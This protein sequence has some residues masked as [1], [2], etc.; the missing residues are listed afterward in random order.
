MQEEVES[1]SVNLAV[2]TS[3]LTAKALVRGLAMHM[4]N[5]K[6]KKET[7]KNEKPT[8]KQTV[9]EL[10][11]Q[12]QG[13]SNMP[14]GEDGL[15][16]FRRIA[17]KYGVDFAIVKD[18]TVHPAKYTVFFKAIDADAFGQILKEYSARM[19]KKQSGRRPSILKRLKKFKE[20]VANLPKKVKEKRKEYER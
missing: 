6:L 16:D 18:K 19:M 17:K 5:R 3:E 7:K 13:V 14:I 1:R 12:N 11:G 20:L 4:R 2:R 8:G 9:K 15:R 10:I